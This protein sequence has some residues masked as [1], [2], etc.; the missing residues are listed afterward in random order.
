MKAKG[1]RDRKRD[2]C[3]QRILEA[4]ATIFR[5]KGFDAARTADI[6]GR[7]NVSVKT[8]YNYFPTKDALLLALVSQ[9]RQ[10]AR[11]ACSDLIHSPPSDP[12]KALLAF[13]YT[14]LDHSMRYLDR[15]VWRHVHAAS[16]LSA[17]H[18]VDDDQ[19]LREW[20]L[21]AEQ[22]RILQALKLRGML[23]RTADEEALAQVV[24]A[25]VF[26]HWQVFLVTDSM[27][28]GK[29]KSVLKR[30]VQAIFTP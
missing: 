10:E 21:I 20:S 14:L 15:T 8:V 1:L 29:L 23:P 25:V 24:H 27:T 22:K 7:A 12:S 26:F 13:H 17:W 9:F 2:E 28:L 11:E 6:A 4:A 16:M 18:V 30:Q 3:R 5:A 19:W